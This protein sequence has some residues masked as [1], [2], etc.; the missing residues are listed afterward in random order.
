M[1]SP[2]E[3]LSQSPVSDHQMIQKAMVEQLLNFSQGK[4]HLLRELII[5]KKKVN[6]RKMQ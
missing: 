3:K 4:G 1:L 6:G 5:K 2:T